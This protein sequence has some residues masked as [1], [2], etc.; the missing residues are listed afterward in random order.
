MT[1]ST[2]RPL[3][4]LKSSSRHAAAWGRI[5]SFGYHLNGTLTS[6]ASKPRAR[7]SRTSWRTCTSAPPCTNGTWASQT[8]TV[9][10]LGGMTEVD[11]VAILHDV[12]LPFEPQ[13][14]VIAARGD[15]A[16]REQVFVAHHLGA[17]ES[18][19][20]IGVNLARGDDR[21]CVARNRPRPVLILTDGEE[22][23][24]AEQVIAGANHAIEARL[25]QSEIGHEGRRIIRFELRDL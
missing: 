9:L 10:T 3:L 21:R 16:A 13:L 8:R 23:D 14:A 19:G 17:D 24:V 20:N 6:S 12:L 22:R 4:S 5:S 25:V 7:S 18:T 11:H 1:R 15:R 2:G